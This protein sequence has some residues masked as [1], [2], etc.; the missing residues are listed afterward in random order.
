MNDAAKRAHQPSPRKTGV[1]RAFGPSYG[2]IRSDDGADV[3]VH[4]TGIRGA[5]FRML[6][7]GQRVEFCVVTDSSGRR[8]AIDV[9]VAEPVAAD[10]PVV[11]RRVVRSHPED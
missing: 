9:R 2:F 7:P 8:V 10:A 1:V 4:F 3:F 5:G 6:V 11:V